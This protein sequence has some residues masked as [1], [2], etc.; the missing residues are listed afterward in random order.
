MYLQ[1][2]ALQMLL[3]FP[4]LLMNFKDFSLAHQFTVI[5]IVRS[6]KY[7]FLLP[8]DFCLEFSDI[9]TIRSTFLFGKD[10]LLVLG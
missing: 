7:W 9:L 6:K 10:S 5:L 8:R 2:M 3:A 1:M 4:E